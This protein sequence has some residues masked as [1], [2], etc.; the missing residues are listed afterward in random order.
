MRLT[1][2][3]PFPCDAARLEAELGDVVLELRGLQTEGWSQ[4]E[5]IREGVGQRGQGEHVAEIAG[6]EPRE[7]TG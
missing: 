2:R 4:D 5:S 7:E 6:A 3:L 1:Y